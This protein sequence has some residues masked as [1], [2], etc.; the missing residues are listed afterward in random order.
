[1]LIHKD[2]H[3]TIYFGSASDQLYPAEY[4]AL[5]PDT[6]LL[7]YP[8]FARLRTITPLQQLYFLRQ[9]HS[10][11]GHTIHD[12]SFLP[13]FAH[14]GDFLITKEKLIGLGVM[15]ADCLP[16]CIY[17]PYQKVSAVI[18][19]GWRGAVAGI[20]QKAITAIQTEYPEN[21]M[22]FFGPAA[23]SCCYQVQE[24]M[25][26]HLPINHLQH[27]YLFKQDDHWYFDNATY[28]K[29]II[30][31][32]G[33]TQK[34]IILNYHRCTICNTEFFSHRRQGKLAGRQMTVMV[35]H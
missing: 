3:F 7:S 28:I 14:E 20:V 8:I 24:D 15:T 32:M 1:M 34:N 23:K 35:T 30:T 18:H 22:V 21:L 12:I 31:Q 6:N 4:L 29:H 25:I 27:T 9:T 16:I 17:D 26:Q 33:V 2:P 13:A 11:I 5:A 10:I 19:A